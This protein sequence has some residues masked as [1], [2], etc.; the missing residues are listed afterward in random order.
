MKTVFKKICKKC[1]GYCCKLP[2]FIT[3]RDIDHLKKYGKEIKVH[4]EFTGA[5]K[6]PGYLVQDDQK[7]CS[8]LNLETGCTLEHED[9]PFDCRVFPVTFKY[10]NGEVTF[11]FNKECKYWKEIPFSW[12]L[13]TKKWAEKVVDELTEEEKI[14]FSKMIERHPELLLIPL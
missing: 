11:Y 7:K 5:N 14:E 9:K 8:F 12:A 4:N 13:E 6:A 10:K 3:E 1:Q 2:V